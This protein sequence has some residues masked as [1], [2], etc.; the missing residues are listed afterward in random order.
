MLKNSPK[1]LNYAQY[2]FGYGFIGAKDFQEVSRIF[3][4]DST[5]IIMLAFSN[6]LIWLV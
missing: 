4:R 2:P 3:D 5:Y 6:D 1:E